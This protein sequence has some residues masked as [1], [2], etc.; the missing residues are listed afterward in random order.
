MALLNE[1]MTALRTQL[2]QLRALLDDYETRDVA[3]QVQIERLGSDLNAALARVASEERKRA[4]AEAE[5]RRLAEEEAARLAEE[6]RLA[7]AEVKDLASYRSEFFG[8][9]RQILGNREGVRVVG[10]RFVFSSEVLFPPGSA[11]LSAGGREQI[12]RVA[13]T[14]SEVA[15]EIPDEID[16]VIRVDG[17]TDRTGVGANSDYADNWEL[18]QARALSVVHYMTRELGFPPNRLAA[19]GFGEFQPVATG[20]SPADY[21]A[22]RRIELKLT[23]K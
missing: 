13:A 6:A 2:A 11:D 17:H 7:Q 16:W 9:M 12:A 20:N 1:Q 10:D 3:A 23:E 15:D 22:N 14:L 5:A 18:S 4:E 8:R 19:T 21:A